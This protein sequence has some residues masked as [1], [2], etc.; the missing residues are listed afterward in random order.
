MCKPSLTRY[1]RTQHNYQLSRFAY[2]HRAHGQSKSM[3]LELRANFVR[4][5]L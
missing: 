5:S 3:L 4:D 2:K 1:A